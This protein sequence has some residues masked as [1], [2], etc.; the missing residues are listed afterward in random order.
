MGLRTNQL[1][2]LSMMALFASLSGCGSNSDQPDLGLV[3]GA[4]TFEGKPLSG[5]SVTFMPDSGRPAM[6]KTDNEG[7]YELVYIRNTPGCKVGRNKVVIYSVVE[8]EDEMEAEGDDVLADDVGPAREK[9][10]ARYNDKTEL[11]VDVKSGENTFDFDL[12]K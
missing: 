9:L 10:P 7:C 4:V 1:M 12:K 11:V 8:G 6:A 3:K 5:A 2:A